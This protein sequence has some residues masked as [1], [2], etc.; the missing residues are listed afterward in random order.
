[1][2]PSSQ[3]S[4]ASNVPLPHVLDTIAT[5]E[6]PDIIKPVLHVNPQVI[7]LHVAVPFAGAVQRVQLGPHAL[8]SFAIVLTHAP[9]HVRCPAGHPPPHVPI[10]QLG[11]APTTESMHT[12]PHMPQFARSVLRL[13]H[14]PLHADSPAG[15]VETQLP[16]THVALPPVGAEQRIPQA[17]QL[18]GSVCKFTHEAPH[19]APAQVVPQVPIEHTSALVHARPHMPQFAV[20]LER[21][22]QRAPQSSCPAGHLHAP[23]TQVCSPMQTLSHAPQWL[24]LLASKTQRPL[25][26]VKPAP[27]G[28]SLSVSTTGCSSL[29]LS[30]ATPPSVTGS[31]A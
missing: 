30:I 1:M 27:Q 6:L 26:F 4:L 24:L 3:V 7:P 8:M 5:H 15:H 12:R 9:M 16:A 18:A 2:L 23:A 13:T 11:V 31:A 21:V 20:S 10:V 14:T 17:P 29:A 22:T 19:I 25:H 28:I